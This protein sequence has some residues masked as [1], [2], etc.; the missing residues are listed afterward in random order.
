[1]SGIRETQFVSRRTNRNKD[2]RNENVRR[3]NRDK[4]IPKE[5][6]TTLKPENDASQ[7]SEHGTKRSHDEARP[8]SM[9][10]HIGNHDA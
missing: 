4:S 1:M 5:D 2:S 3:A 9:A 10:T 8:H 7:Y 6:E